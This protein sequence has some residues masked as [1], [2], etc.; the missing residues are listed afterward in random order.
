MNKDTLE[1]LFE[2]NPNP[3]IKSENGQTPLDVAT[4]YK[5]TELIAILES[6]VLCVDGSL[7]CVAC[8]LCSV[9]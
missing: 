6:M 9:E 7:Q 2:H 1:L 3:T 8:L 5:A 4:E